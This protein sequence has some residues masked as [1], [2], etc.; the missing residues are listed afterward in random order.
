MPDR[1][2]ESGEPEELLSVFGFSSKHIVK[3]VKK[4]L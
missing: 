2:G 3:E 4:L 1:Y